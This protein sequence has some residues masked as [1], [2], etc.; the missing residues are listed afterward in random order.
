MVRF[1]LAAGIGT[2][3][4]LG[5]QPDHVSRQVVQVQRRS[6]EQHASARDLDDTLVDPWKIA[7]GQPV[8]LLFVR[9]DCPISNRYAPKITKLQ[10]EFQGKVRF[11][12]VYPDADESPARIRAHL[13]EYRYATPALRD[14]R[15]EL[16]Q[17]AHATITPETAVFNG[18]GELLYHGRIDNWYEDLGRARQAA[19]THE[20]EDAVRAALENK[21]VN[22]DHANA[23]G[24]YIADIK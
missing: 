23:V 13:R 19:T 21:R 17:V 18:A 9:T 2:V 24:C 6:A 5:N 10:E 15:H 22:P 8:V 1:I 4:T 3:L 16:V 11:W 20:L 12:L 7:S 14:V